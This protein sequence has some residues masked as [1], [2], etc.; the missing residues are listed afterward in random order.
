L[1]AAGAVDTNNAPVLEIE[2]GAPPELAES[3]DGFA[4]L[5]RVRGC[6]DPPVASD[7]P[8]SE[9][10]FAPAVVRFDAKLTVQSTEPLRLGDAHVPA[11]LAWGLGCER[12]RCSVLA[13]MGDSPVQ[14][15]AIDLAPR[16]NRFHAP[17]TP[18]PPPDAPRLAQLETLATGETLA[19][20]AA[21]AVGDRVF[22]ATLTSALEEPGKKGSPAG[23]SG[24][25]GGIVALRVIGADGR[26]EGAPS[27]LTRRALSVGGVAISGGEKPDDGAAVAWIARDEGDPEVHVT[28]VDRNGKRLQEVRLTMTKG[29][30][31]DVAIAWADGGWLLAWV[32]TRDGNGEVYAAKVGLDLSR[33]ARDERITNAP[34][35]ASD[36]TLI[37]REHGAWLAWADPRESPHDGF[38]DIFAAALRGRDARPEVPELRVLGTAAHSRSPSLAVSDQSGVVLAWIEEAPMGVEAANNGAYGAMFAWLD[39]QGHPVAEPARTRGAGD[40]SPTSV[41]LGRTGGQL[42]AIIA[43]S[44]RDELSLDALVVERGIL[45]VPFPV[46]A[47]DGPPSLDVSMTLLGDAIYFNDEGPEAGDGRA[48]RARL[49]FGR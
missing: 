26:L 37:A 49:A 32:D 40:G 2:G 36:V 22:F 6:T 9:A 11:Q 17:L 20:V 10:R 35:D 13:A 42:R 29:D 21:I 48:R 47:L 25:G 39:G 38:A 12:D 45:G 46:L 43:R 33:L 28:R 5:A 4:L 15:S 18:T 16:A 44:A 27:I 23:G 3:D 14:I 19:D 30:A 24:S 8:C 1:D 34:G 41:V 31:S 7:P